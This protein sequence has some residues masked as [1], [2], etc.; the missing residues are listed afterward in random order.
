[1]VL[2][3]FDIATVVI[4]VEIALVD[5]VVVCVAVVVFPEQLLLVIERMPDLEQRHWIVVKMKKTHLM[6]ANLLTQDD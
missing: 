4:D 2:I 3:P 5:F 1:L 6:K